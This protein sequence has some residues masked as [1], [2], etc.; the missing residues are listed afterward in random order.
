MRPLGGRNRWFKSSLTH[1]PTQLALRVGSVSQNYAKIMKGFSTLSRLLF[2][3][4]SDK[5]QHG[6]DSDKSGEDEQDKTNITVETITITTDQ[7]DER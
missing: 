3:N 2:G 1:W 7:T 5:D 4:S 6:A